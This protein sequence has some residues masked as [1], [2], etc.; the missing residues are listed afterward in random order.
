LTRVPPW[1]S[2]MSTD[3]TPV[4]LARRTT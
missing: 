4:R 2:R 3:S 1:L